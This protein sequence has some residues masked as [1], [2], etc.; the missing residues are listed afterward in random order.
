MKIVAFKINKPKPFNY[1]PL[2]YDQKKEEMQERLK[3]YTDPGEQNAERL[4][5]R[6]R[7]SW[8][9]KEARTQALSK[10]TL[11]IYLIGVAVILYYIF[12]R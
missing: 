1:K 2:Y 8:K 11:I 9:V 10:R 12:M 7:E 4:R 5:M 3:K 6:L